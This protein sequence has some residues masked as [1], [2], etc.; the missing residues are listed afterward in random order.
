[1]GF[2]VSFVRLLFFEPTRPAESMR[3]FLAS[4]TSVLVKG[5][6]PTLKPSQLRQTTQN[7][8][9]ALITLKTPQFGLAHSQLRPREKKKIFSIPTP[10]RSPMRSP[11]PKSSS[12]RRHHW[13][14]DNSIPSL[15]S[16]K[17]WFP[18]TQTNSISIHTLKPS[19]FRPPQ[20]KFIP[21]QTLKSRQV[22]S[23]T[24]K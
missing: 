2:R 18:D 11:T 23:P 22:Q 7:P 19:I 10:K 4:L 17:L 9:Q 12:F 1:M 21:I 14:Q 24:K 8:S 6:S 15:K 3:P 20:Q 13:H 16:S 5:W